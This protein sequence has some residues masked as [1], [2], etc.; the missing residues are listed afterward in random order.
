MNVGV[1]LLLGMVQLCDH[2]EQLSL[3]LVSKRKYTTEQ[4][5][6]PSQLAFLHRKFTFI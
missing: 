6:F 4:S 3:T 5:L 1:R 2:V